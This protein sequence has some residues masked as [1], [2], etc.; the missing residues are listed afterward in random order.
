MIRIFALLAVVVTMSACTK[1]EYASHLVKKVLPRQVASTDNVG[2]G[3]NFKVGNPYKIAGRWYYPKEQYDLVETGIASWY[4]PGFHGKKT[5]NGDTFNQHELTA[6]HRTLQM[7]SLVRV[8]NLENGRAVIVR[9]NDRGPYKRGRVIDVS[10]RV[11]ELLGFKGKG[12]A[13]VKLQVMKQESLKVARAAKSGQSTRGYEVAMNGGGAQLVTAQ[14]VSVTQPYQVASIQPAAAP[15][16]PTVVAPVNREMLSTPGTQTGITNIVPG[17]MNAGGFYPDPVITEY[18]VA[19]TG[20]YVQA[21]SFSVAG[22]AQALTTRLADYNRADVYTAV[23]DG[24]TFYRV[25]L[26]PVSSVEEA[27]EL[28]ARIVQNGHREAMIVVE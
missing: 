6:A 23:I 16:Q 21:G 3:G 1:I 24:K 12:T 11:A 25:R 15:D 20:I 14:P 28:L 7:P 19:Q 8:T 13:K 17:H 4:G 18:P 26:G 27:D 9:V 2:A 5:A 22:N 10:E